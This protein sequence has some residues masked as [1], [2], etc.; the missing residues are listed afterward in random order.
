MDKLGIGIVGLGAIGQRLMRSFN[1]DERFEIVAICDTNQALVDEY[2]ELYQV[3]LATNRV[4]DLI[5]SEDVDWV[6]VAVPP[7]FH[8]DI[9]RKAFAAGKH[10][11]CEKPLANSLAEAQTMAALAMAGSN[12]H[13]LHL[14]LHFSPAYRAFHQAVHSGY[15]GD[16]LAVE[17]RLRFP[18]WPRK[19]Q[20]TA[21]VGQR[22]EGGFVREV[23]PHFI[24]ALLETFGSIRK[25]RL[26][27]QYP[28]D[29]LA[30]EEIAFGEL[31]LVSGVYVTFSGVA[32]MVGAED[33]SLT[34]YG[35][36][37]T[38]LF[39]NWSQTLGTKSDAPFSP[40]PIM[41]GATLL[42]GLVDGSNRVGFEFGFAIQAVLE[43]L[44]ASAAQNGEWLDVPRMVI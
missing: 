39:K 25:V 12:G 17:I 13:A 3:A 20:N 6:Y 30:S 36:Q 11:L 26:Q 15:T 27:L 14:P 40:L 2:S 31:E 37:G 16:L 42:D 24:G 22:K 9:V 1:T 33:V 34:A 8:E 38:L 7:S 41:P 32:H 4:E 19:W 44:F 28:Q 21:W 29:S 43:S 23:G 10:V 5:V 18:L 35:R